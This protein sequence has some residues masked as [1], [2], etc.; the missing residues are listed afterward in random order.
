[1]CHGCDVYDDCCHDMILFMNQN[2]SLLTTT[3]FLN[4][5]QRCNIKI[6][7]F[8]SVYSIEKCADW[9]LKEANE[10]DGQQGDREII[11]IKCENNSSVDSLIDLIPVYSNGT[12]QTYKNLYCAQCNFKDRGK[13]R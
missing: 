5:N 7:G 4:D 9:W 8:K 10:D 12:N 1:M 11:R 2:S 3:R 13:M 6:D